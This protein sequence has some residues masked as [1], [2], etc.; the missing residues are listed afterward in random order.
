MPKFKKGDRVTVTDV[1]YPPQVGARREGPNHGK[2][3][4]IAAS[5][6]NPHGYWRVTGIP[7]ATYFPESELRK[8]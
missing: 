6:P 7:G 2:T 8:A 5:S 1:S 4:T 3:G